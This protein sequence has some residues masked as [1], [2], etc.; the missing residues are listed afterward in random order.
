MLD[1]LRRLNEQRMGDGAPLPPG[2][3]PI[4]DSISI[5]MASDNEM[6]HRHLI[7]SKSP[8]AA[9]PHPMGVLIRT[10]A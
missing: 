4:A 6:G 10:E 1:E 8:S 7:T 5:D 9:H 3:H 2:P